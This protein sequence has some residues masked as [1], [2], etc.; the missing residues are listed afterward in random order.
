[1]SN[2]DSRMMRI[3]RFREL[4]GVEVKPMGAVREGRVEL[5]AGHLWEALPDAIRRPRTKAKMFERMQRKHH[6]T[7]AECDNYYA[8]AK[9]FL[10]VNGQYLYWDSKRGL[11]KAKNPAEGNILWKHSRVVTF[12]LTGRANEYGVCLADDRV[13]GITKMG[14]TEQ[15]LLPGR[16]SDEEAQ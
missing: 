11:R 15:G 9:R 2:K 1:M 14:V 13:A 6:W 10:A 16:S 5:F 12:G 7:P 3:A 4:Y 8:D